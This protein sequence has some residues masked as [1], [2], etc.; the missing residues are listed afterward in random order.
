MWVLPEKQMCFLAN[1]KTASLATAFTLETLGFKHYGDQHC[2]PQGSGWSR[3]EEIDDTWTIFCT[4]RHHYDV[5]VSWYFHNTRTPASKYFGYPFERFLYEW[6][7]NPEWFQNNRMYWKHY[8]LCNKVLRYEFLQADFHQLLIFSG[9]PLTTLQVH[10]VSKNRRGRQYQGFYSPKSSAFMED[11]FGAEMC[12]LN[13][14]HW[15]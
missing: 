3:R 9:L 6:A 7:C 12:L 8:P 2:T 4:V 11:K 14:G 5:M 15:S 1:P 13:Y 10:N